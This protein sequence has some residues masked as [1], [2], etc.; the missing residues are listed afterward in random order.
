LEF[1]SEAHET[2]ATHDR[3]VDGMEE[4]AVSRYFTSQRIAPLADN[5]P[6]GANARKRAAEL[7]PQSA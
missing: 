2:P 7:S 5:R 6:P 1:T 3:L 4:L